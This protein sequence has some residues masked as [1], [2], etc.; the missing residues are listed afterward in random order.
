ELAPGPALPVHVGEH[1]SL[2]PRERE[3]VPLVAHGPREGYG[4]RVAGGGE[5]VDHGA[6]RVAETQV[7]SHLVEGLSGGVVQRLTEDLVQAV[8][9]HVHEQGVAAGHDERDRRRRIVRSPRS[10][11]AEVSSQEVSIARISVSGASGAGSSSSGSVAGSRSGAASS[12]SSANAS[13]KETSGI[14]TPGAGPAV[15]PDSASGKVAS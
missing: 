4:R 2:Q 9:E 6:S 8:V 11:A 1:G 3:V 12:R 5:L 10:T 14:A 13:A 7:A 15:P